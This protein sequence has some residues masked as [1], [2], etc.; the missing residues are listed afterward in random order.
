MTLARLRIAVTVALTT[1]FACAHAPAQAP[2]AAR[3]T[4]ALT[5][6]SERGA[7]VTGA[8]AELNE[9]VRQAHRAARAQG[10]EQLDG[11]RLVIRFAF[12]KLEARWKGEALTPEGL[13]VFPAEYH[14]LKD[15]AHAVLL[16]ALLFEEGPGPARDRRVADA[17]R[18]LQDVVAEIDG[19]GAAGKLIPAGQ[20]PRQRRVLELT[21]A[22]LTRF[23]SGALGDRERREYFAAVRRDLT[24]TMHVVSAALLR[25]LDREVKAI[26]AR[27]DEAAWSSALVLVAAVHQA[28]A[29]EIGAQYFERLLGEPL[30][31]GARNE[32]RLVVSENLFTSADQYGLLATHLVDAAVAAAIFDDPLR[33]QRDAL[34]DVGDVL[35][36]LLPAGTAS[37]R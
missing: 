35:D 25:N 26:R 31:E 5:P 12:G 22:A 36:E 16:A 7:G 30:G 9:Q 13:D 29:R 10:C 4:A 37:R 3:C 18:A 20:L 6:T 15:V 32:R 34:G 14:P 19:A 28:R 8:L 1:A 27:V 33:L 23:Q 11:D 21:G 2:T 24:E 17:I